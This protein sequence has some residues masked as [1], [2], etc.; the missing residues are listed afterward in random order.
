MFESTMFHGSRSARGPALS[1]TIHCGAVALLV[2][3]GTRP[4]IRLAL[5]NTADAVRVVAPYMPSGHGGGGGGNRSPIPASYGAL[6][7]SAPRQFV[8]PTTTLNNPNPALAMDPAL[9]LSPNADLPHVNVAELGDPFGKLGLKS[10]GPGWGGGIGT[11]HD[12]GVGPGDGPGLGPGSGGNHGGGV[13][14][15]DAG[16]GAI[17][18]PVLLY[19][20]EPEFSEEARKAKH[21]GVV[22]L[23]AEVGTNGALENI[24]VI[25]GLG[26][27][28]DEKAI[29][30]VKQWRFRPAYRNG[31]PVATAAN[32][33]VNFHLL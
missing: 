26:L 22:I 19:K 18:G 25:Q 27:G 24:R 32:I 15:L 17:T 29:A 5:R 16:R 3:A 4:E 33:E 11:G 2:A 1:F 13:R 8:P 23:Y 28:L 7:K 12:G 20:V 10:D 9:I 14:G 6:P 30:A 31:Q 21:Q